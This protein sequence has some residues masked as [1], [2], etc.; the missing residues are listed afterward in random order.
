MP[1]LTDYE[2]LAKFAANESG[3][4]F[5]T[6][7]GRYVNLVYSTG[8]RF[9]GNPHHAEEITQAV[10]VIL[11]RKAWQLSP[12]TVLS[13]WL[14]QT[15]R[16]TAANLVRGEIRRQRRDQEAYMQSTLTESDPAA[17]EQVA[18][19]LD[20]AMGQL[21][22]TD[23]N[24]V[25]L[26]YF[27]NKTAH[28]VGTAL[29]LT[30][31]AAHKRV[32]RALEKLRRFFTKRGVTLSAV[33]LGA[34]MSANSLQAAPSGLAITVSGTAGI[35]MSATL[36]TLVETTM[37]TMTWL[38]LKFA[39]GVGAAA[40]LAGGVATVA[41]SQ[42][43]G[44]EKS[45]PPPA[46]NSGNLTPQEIA[47]KSR[48]AYAALS[49]YS[50][51]G[52]TVSSIGSTIVAPH[53]FTIKLA[54]P[55]LY[56]IEWKQNVM[57]FYSQKGTVWSAGNGD[58]LQT[59]GSPQKCS[60]KEMALSSA[61]GISGGAA[62]SIPGTFFKM[63]W[64][65]QFGGSMKTA[66]RK[67]DEK[68]GGTDCYV[69]AEDKGSGRTRTLWIGKQDFLIRQIENDTS[70]AAMKTML[71]AEAKKHP[72]LKQIQGMSVAGDAKSVETH[73]NITV[74]QQFSPVDFA[75]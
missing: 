40:L 74:N 26:R 37:K 69:V 57:A 4:A 64:G 27:E 43:G 34:A 53:S 25:V 2:L 29:R 7:V 63:N 11:A 16:L 59:S 49:S 67:A 66:Q 42:I 6:L 51:D 50:D 45:V 13:G 31:A 46:A 28:E 55:G 44:G 54:Q 65:N 1:E 15:T 32:N 19:L 30:D 62:G 21:G 47:G 36:A 9:A 56:R 5:A 33:A 12:R 73:M 35:I 68:I 38:K 22:E 24:A 20:E 70:A 60:D 18:P 52:K 14:Y 10:F 72:E 61:T 23:R 71:D 48:D 58:F 8:L 41:I 3:E 75:L 39:I 17:W